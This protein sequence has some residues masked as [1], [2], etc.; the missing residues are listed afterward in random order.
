MSVTKP[1]MLVNATV[2]VP[3]THG[4][5]AATAQKNRPVSA[6]RGTNG[7]RVTRP[8]AGNWVSGTPH[9][10]GTVTR[11][12]AMC[13]KYG[14]T[15]GAGTN[16]AN[17]AAIKGPPPKPADSTIVARRGP[18]DGRSTD[19]CL[20][21]ADPEDMAMP[22]PKPMIHRPTYSTHSG[23]S[24]PAARMPEATATRISAGRTTARRP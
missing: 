16:W 3:K 1:G 6:I 21:H 11:T 2:A 15:C 7:G 14:V 17:C 12:S 10:S 24:L 5:H 22:T 9:T 4:A 13:S 20:I 8:A 23:A 18:A 19:S